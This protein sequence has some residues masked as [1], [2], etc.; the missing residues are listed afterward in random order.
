MAKD[1]IV[2]ADLGGAPLTPEELAAIP[3]FS[4]I[5]KEVW[6]KSPGAISRKEYS[7]G[8]LLM[9]EG[10]NGT[11]A[12]YILSGSVEI[13]LNNPVAGIQSSRRAVPKGFF[14]SL[15]K[16]SNYVMGVPDRGEKNRP[17]RT[18]IPMDSPADPPFATPP[19]PLAAGG[20]LGR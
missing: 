8:D 16:I 11:T 1:V 12:F 20:F 17:K 5:R 7:P 2:P 9:R 10:E 6:S 14:R 13:F 19:A 18:H 3:D 15:T 4:G